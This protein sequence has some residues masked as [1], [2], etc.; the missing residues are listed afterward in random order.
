[1]NGTFFERISETSKFKL[2]NVTCQNK[3]QTR[4]TRTSNWVTSHQQPRKR[5]KEIKIGA[6]WGASCELSVLLFFFCTVELWNVTA[7][8]TSIIHEYKNC[9]RKAI[10]YFTDFALALH[11]LN[12]VWQDLF[13]EKI[14]N[15]NGCRKGPSRNF[16]IEYFLR[17]FEMKY[18]R[19]ERLRVLCFE[20]RVCFKPLFNSRFKLHTIVYIL[21][22]LTIPSRLNDF[23]ENL[24]SIY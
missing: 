10:Y 22:S 7:E 14:R 11:A 19:V 12:L 15:T 3:P 18:R 24:Y 13:D 6:S 8:A 16:H 23:F 21:L 17:Q 5:K 20:P 1:M 4:R 2:K 9:R